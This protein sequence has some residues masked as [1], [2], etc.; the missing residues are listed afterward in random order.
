MTDTPR[1]VL[2]DG[3]A[4]AA[5]SDADGVPDAQDACPGRLS[6][7]GA[8]DGA[9]CPARFDRNAGLAFDDRKHRAWYGRFWTGRCDGLGF[10]DF[11][12]QEGGSWPDTIAATLD[13]LPPAQRPRARA[14]MLA[15][16]RMIG[17][18]WARDNAIRKIDT[19]DLRRWRT[20]LSRAGD[21]WAAL[22][23]ICREAAVA[24]GAARR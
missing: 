14:E 1:A 12:S 7:Q 10:F 2:L 6:G 19:A 5:D 4:P 11:C 17:F 21:R 24:V 13:N 20:E 23:R 18:E 3:V 9:G 15:M 16:G 22:G 8:I